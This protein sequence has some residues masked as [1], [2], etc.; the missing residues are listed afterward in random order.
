MLVLQWVGGAWK[1]RIELAVVIKKVGI[2]IYYVLN[3][4]VTI[5]I[6]RVSR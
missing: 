2:R 6:K 3:F 1:A 4:L 5:V